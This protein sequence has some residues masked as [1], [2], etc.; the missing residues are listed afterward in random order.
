MKLTN[1]QVLD[2]FSGLNKLA[3]EKF[4]AKL[5][6]KIQTARSTLQ[7]FA[8]SVSKMVSEVQDKHAIKDNLGQNVLATDEDGNEVPNTLT[9]SRESIAVINKEIGDLLSTKVDVV[10]VSLS[11]SDFPDTFEISAN[12]LAALESVISE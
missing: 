7:P 1:Q 10:N 6:W 3:E 8:E 9:F 4:S 11:L 2:V 5:S 12:T